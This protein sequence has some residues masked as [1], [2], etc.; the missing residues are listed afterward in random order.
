[1]SYLV[2]P[3]VI[4]QHRDNPLAVDITDRD[5]QKCSRN[6]HVGFSA[7]Q[8][9]IQEDL[10]GT[11]AVHTFRSEV[12][13]FYVQSLTYIK[14]KF[15]LKDEVVVNAQ[16]LDPR[17]RQDITPDFLI[18][19]TSWFP[20]VFQTDELDK[21]SSELC[22]YQAANDLPEAD[23]RI[24]HFWHALS[25]VRNEGDNSLRFQYLALLGKVY[26]LIPHSN[27]RCET[28]FN[29]VRKVTTDV[30]SQLGKGKGGC[31]QD[32]VYSSTTG[33]RNNLCAVLA[34]KINIFCHTECFK[35]EPTQKLLSTAKSATYDV[36]QARSKELKQQ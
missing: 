13:S 34:S 10:E 8:H 17:R 30:R 36:L 11:P 23:Q 15:P 29:M 24:D 1:M 31:C 27:A 12:R 19:F 5:N 22:D 35:W 9:I 25:T 20:D 21:L 32:S 16:Y 2:K 26:L 28:L 33:I 18:K 7:S 3:D 14:K 4:Q 6:M